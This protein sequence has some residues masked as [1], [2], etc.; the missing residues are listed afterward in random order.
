M[1]F[2]TVLTPKGN[3]LSELVLAKGSV[4]LSLTAKSNNQWFV[5]SGRLGEPSVCVDD[6]VARRCAKPGCS[7]A[8]Y[9][10]AVELQ[11][12]VWNHGSARR[13][14]RAAP[15]RRR[16]QVADDRPGHRRASNNRQRRC[17][18]S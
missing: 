11:S 7:L 2:Q 13:L 17:V 4:W 14:L 15:F 18:R 6:F 5:L 1:A 16:P 12:L 9:N 8:A 3:T 10:E